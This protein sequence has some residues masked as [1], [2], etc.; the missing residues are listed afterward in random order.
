MHERLIHKKILLFKIWICFTS[1]NYEKIVAH[2]NHNQ[3]EPLDPMHQCCG[4][5][6]AQPLYNFKTR[7]LLV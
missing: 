7:T 6:I 5:V 2:V 4:F 1:L 3:L